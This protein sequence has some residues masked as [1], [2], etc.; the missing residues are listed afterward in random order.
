MRQIVITPKPVVTPPTTFKLDE[1]LARLERDSK[2]GG[3]R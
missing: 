2:F 1:R 3:W